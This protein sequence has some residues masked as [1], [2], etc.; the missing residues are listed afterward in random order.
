MEMALNKLH[1][2]YTTADSLK[3]ESGLW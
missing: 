2:K 1:L 3:D